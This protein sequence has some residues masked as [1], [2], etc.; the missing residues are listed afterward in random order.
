MLSLHP[1][2]P[3]ASWRI[4][5]N[6]SPLDCPIDTD[7]DLGAMQLDI[8]DPRVQLKQR[9]FHTH[10]RGNGYRLNHAGLVS[11]IHENIPELPEKL[12]R[13]RQV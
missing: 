11:T 4:R 1:P 6:I 13:C 9:S 12:S 3:R 8:G 2:R 10:H 7:A 5:P